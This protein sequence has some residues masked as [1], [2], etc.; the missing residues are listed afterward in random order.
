MAADHFNFLTLDEGHF[1]LQVIS[2]PAKCETLFVEKVQL[3]EKR[4]THE[5]H[6]LL[7][8][9]WVAIPEAEFE[10]VRNVIGSDGLK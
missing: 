7:L 9:Y 5:F 10:E 6:A 1:E 3:L 2:S 8:L 4:P